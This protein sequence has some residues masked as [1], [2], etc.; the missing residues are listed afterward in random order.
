VIG[1]GGVH[2]VTVGLAEGALG[3]SLPNGVRVLG[4]SLL[5][6]GL[7][8]G[9]GHL[10][11]FGL[12]RVHTTVGRTNQSTIAARRTLPSHPLAGLLAG[13]LQLLELETQLRNFSN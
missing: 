1:E 13:G 6:L 5:G 3:V 4:D 12:S 7:F 11:G 8:A 10:G 2:T 9:A